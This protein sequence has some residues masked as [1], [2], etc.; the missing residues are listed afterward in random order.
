M[1]DYVKLGKPTYHRKRKY[2][3][4]PATGDTVHEI[5]LDYLSYPVIPIKL[6]R[7]DY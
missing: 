7:K 6:R 5:N 1:S 2:Y 3:T 4:M